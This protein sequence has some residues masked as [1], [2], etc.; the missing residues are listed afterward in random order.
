MRRKCGDA[1]AVEYV[2]ADLTGTLGL[3]LCTL[4]FAFIGRYVRAMDRTTLL[5]YII[6]ATRFFPRIFGEWCDEDL[7]KKLI[8]KAANVTLQ[9]NANVS[10]SSAESNHLARR[11]ISGVVL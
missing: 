5:Y 4:V 10:L 8:V 7:K 6:T 3:V 9:V 11:C 2:R 1:P